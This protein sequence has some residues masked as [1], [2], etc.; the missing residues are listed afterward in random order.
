VAR[1]LRKSLVD[2]R[3]P[4][5]RAPNAPT[6]SATRLNPQL[7]QGERNMKQFHIPRRPLTSALLVV[8]GTVT[9]AAA[10]GTTAPPPASLPAPAAATAASAAG[11]GSTVAP[12][13]SDQLDATVAPIALYPDSLVAQILSASQFPDQ[14]ALA[15]YWVQQN[16][17]LSSA[18]L[19]TEVD[20]QTWDPS[21]KAL[22]QFPTVLHDLATNLAWTSALGEAFH[23]QQADVMAAVQAMRAKA[24]SAGNLTSTTQIK[25][26]QQDPH[27][28]VIQP[29][30]PDVVYVPRYNPTIVYGA[31][32]V[33]PYYVPAYPVVAGAA[34]SFGTGVAVGAVIGGGFHWGFGSWGMGWGGGWGGG[35]TVIYNH[36]T[37]INKTVWNG[38]RYNYNGYHPWGP[39]G[40]GPGQHPGGWDPHGGGWSQHGNWY[41]NGHGG[42]DWQRNGGPN[43]DHGLIGGNGGVQ[44]ANGTEGATR[45]IG[46][47]NSRPGGERQSHWSGDGASSRAER[48]RGVGA[49]HASRAVS[50]HGGE[51]RR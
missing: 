47:N 41:P 38:N 5:F 22:S 21:V 45:S 42:S 51:H 36:N 26:V 40:E 7:D 13:T 32:Y 6:F 19:A 18:A 20:K 49:M 33:V 16:K 3:R 1:A 14:I 29:A 23:Y 27:T 9:T 39:H 24:Q 43:G 11:T 48:S 35:N 10:F 34:I 31:P 37:Y 12:Q 46:A 44:H 15:D 50:S 8:L 25:V 17:S 4:G 28:I 2:D 30:S